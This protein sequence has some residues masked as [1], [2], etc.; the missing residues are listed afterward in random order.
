MAQNDKTKR[1]I[2]LGSRLYKARERA[3]LTQATLQK[4][5]IIKQ[6]HLS[7][8]ENGE[9]SVSALLLFDL[10]KRYK[11]DMKYFFE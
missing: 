10:S 3:G 6:S 9:L 8:L 5:G 2:Y 4:E 7:K 1:Q 11:V